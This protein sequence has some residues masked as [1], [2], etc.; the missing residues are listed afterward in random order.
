MTRRLAISVVLIVLFSFAAVFGWRW[1]G[2]S[3]RETNLYK[4]SDSLT[5]AITPVNGKLVNF[6]DP[7]APYGTSLRLDLTNSKVNDEW[8]TAHLPSKEF[9]LAKE[10]LLPIRM[11]SGKIKS[12]LETNTELRDR[13]KFR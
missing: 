7:D 4:L 11:K 6:A 1:I 13:V 3:T 5:A 12:L 9:Q 2:K 8:I 10:I